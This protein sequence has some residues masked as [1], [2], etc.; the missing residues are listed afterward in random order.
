M[1][2]DWV[3]VRL[4]NE[5]IMPMNVALQLLKGKCA[6]KMNPSGDSKYVKVQQRNNLVSLQMHT[7]G[8]RK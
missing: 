4:E 5:E 1:S 6:L 3:K 7:L 2:Q 8:V